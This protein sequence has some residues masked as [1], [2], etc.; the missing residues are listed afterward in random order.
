MDNSNIDPLLP[1]CR[2]N[3]VIFSG[4]EVCDVKEVWGSDYG[5]AN[6]DGY[7]LEMFRRAFK[8]RN[9]GAQRWLQHRLGAVVLDWVHGHPRKELACSLHTEEY[10]VIQTFK[11]CWQSSLRH[12]GFEFGVMADVLYYLRVCLNGVILDE[13][14]S[15]SRPDRTLLVKSVAERESNSDGD[16]SGHEVWMVIEG[17]LPDARERRLAYLLFD[18]A[19]RPVEIVRRCPQEFNDVRE[20]S[21]LRR[22]IIELL[23][24]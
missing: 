10:Y 13:L 17:K 20:V 1:D 6:H 15:Y 9:Q 23:S 3:E 5:D 21:R 8:E 2:S 24:Q 18:C 7:Y 12:E 14:R 4:F 16:D 22:D 11:R 19:F